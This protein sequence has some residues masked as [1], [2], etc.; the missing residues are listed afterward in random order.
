MAGLVPAIHVF[1]LRCGQDV[2]AR[3]KPGHDGCWGRNWLP[4]WPAPAIRR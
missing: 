1:L 2:A 3:V 4:E